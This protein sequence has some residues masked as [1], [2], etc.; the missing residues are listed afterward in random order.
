[1]VASTLS[2]ESQAASILCSKQPIIESDKQACR[3]TI[4]QLWRACYFSHISRCCLPL[5]I[6]ISSNITSHLLTLVAL[7]IPCL[8]QFQPVTRLFP[9]DFSQSSKGIRSLRFSRELSVAVLSI[10]VHACLKLFYL[11]CWRN[12]QGSPK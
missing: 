7:T 4:C 2:L 6:S 5:Q 1:M 11:L 12:K 10:H 3:R 8:R 9:I